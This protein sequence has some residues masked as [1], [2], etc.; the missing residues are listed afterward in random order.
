MLFKK[1]KE[2]IIIIKTC[3]ILIFFI[4]SSTNSIVS[5]YAKYEQTGSSF[6]EGYTDITVTQAYELLNTTDNGIQIPIDVRTDSEWIGERINTV[7]PEDPRHHCYYDWDDPLVLEEFMQQYK[8]GQK[9]RNH[10]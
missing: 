10:L 4:L 1:Y 3:I 9:C 2:K 6:D 8:G 5:S 7:Y